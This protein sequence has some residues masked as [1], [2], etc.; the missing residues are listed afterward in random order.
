MD[1]G[2]KKTNVDN[3]KK[4]FDIRRVNP[5]IHGLKIGETNWLYGKE[6]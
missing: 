1:T 2:L 4:V 5:A 3:K 6:T